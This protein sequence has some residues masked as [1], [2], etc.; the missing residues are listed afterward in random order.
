MA[1]R[2]TRCT[3]WAVAGRRPRPG[4]SCPAARRPPRPPRAHGGPPHG[5]RR[6]PAPAP[7]PV[8][9]PEDENVLPF[10]AGPG[11]Q[12]GR[13]LPG[14]RIGPRLAGSQQAAPRSAGAFRGSGRPERRFLPSGA[15]QAP[16]A[17]R[18]RRRAPAARPCP[19][20]ARRGARKGRTPPGQGRHRGRGRCRPRRPGARSRNRSILRTA[21]SIPARP[22]LFL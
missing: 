4:P 14:T 1:R 12:N 7:F 19:G 8:S 18:P 17:G 16:R 15:R 9:A 10:R 21:G 20:P 22:C 13:D 5:G 11:G 6:P 3:L 2:T